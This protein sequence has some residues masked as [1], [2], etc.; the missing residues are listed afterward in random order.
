VVWYLHHGQAMADVAGARRR[1]PWYRH[2]RQPAFADMLRAARRELWR[3]RIRADPRYEAGLDEFQELLLE[4][5]L[6]A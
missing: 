5:L 4:Q 6:A 3:A 2:K 1:S